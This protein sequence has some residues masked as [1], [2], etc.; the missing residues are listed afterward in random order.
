[1]IRKL[2]KISFYTL[3][4]LVILSIIFGIAVYIKY[5]NIENINIPAKY[6]KTEIVP[7]KNITLG[8]PVKVT[9]ELKIPWDKK[10]IKLELLLGKGSQQVNEGVFIKENHQWGFNIW[11]ISYIIQPYITGKIP[12]GKAILTISADK[13]GKISELNLKIPG[14]QSNEINV[15]NNDLNIA[16]SINT[17]EKTNKNY[18]MYYI[19]GIIILLIIII[20]AHILITKKRRSKSIILTS[21]DNALLELSQLKNK[22]R[23]KIFG[24]ERSMSTLTDIVRS[25]LQERFEIKA[26]KQTTEEFLK[27]MEGWKSPLSNQDRNFLREFMVQA[28]MIKFARFDATENQLI[29]AIDRAEQLVNETTPKPDKEN[30]SKD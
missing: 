6:L 25:Y 26:P 12:E 13:N 20:S 23:D 10:P 3:T 9:Y 15:T 29:S 1:M 8:E 30:K 18:K 2:L 28:D 7:Q 24:A 19:I 16:G 27:D 21:W 14:F 22:V 4:A 17:S 11:N 5:K